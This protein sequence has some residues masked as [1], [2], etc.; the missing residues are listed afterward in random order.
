MFVLYLVHSCQQSDGRAKGRKVTS[1]SRD[2][3]R[4][5]DNIRSGAS[6][7]LRLPVPNFPS[8]TCSGA[9]I[10]HFMPL[11]IYSE[12]ESFTDV[13]A[14]FLVARTEGIDGPINIAFW[15]PQAHDCTVV[16]FAPVD[17][18]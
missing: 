7:S 6:Q 9:L 17:W 16:A 18:D 14:P 2:E 15:P 10:I 5:I 3:V 13:D 12:V 8:R 11:N 4:C 1:Y